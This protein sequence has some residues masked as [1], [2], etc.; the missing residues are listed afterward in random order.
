[1]CSPRIPRDRANDRNIEFAG[2]LLR[3][4]STVA[5]QHG[6]DRHAERLPKCRND[7]T[8][9]GDAPERRSERQR[10]HIA[11]GKAPCG[12]LSAA[13]PSAIEYD[14]AVLAPHGSGEPIAD[15]HQ[16]GRRLLTPSRSQHDPQTR[17]RLHSMLGEYL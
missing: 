17:M 3:A 5:D 4:V 8:A 11:S 2:D 15:R 6:D 12:R 14:G 9:M 7:T 13:P 16:R 1:M 10:D